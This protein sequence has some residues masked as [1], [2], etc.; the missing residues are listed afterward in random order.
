MKFI[1]EPMLMQLAEP[2]YMCPKCGDKFYVYDVDKKPSKCKNCGLVFEWNF[3]YDKFI[4]ENGVYEL[5]NG[6][7]IKIK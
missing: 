2:E 4:D 5:E 6:K 3:A 1:P 7:L